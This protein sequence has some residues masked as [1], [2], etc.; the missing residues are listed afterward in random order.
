MR[1]W[2]DNPLQTDN[3]SHEIR[4]VVALDAPLP[5]YKQ[6]HIFRLGF[7]FLDGE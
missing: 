3:L 2:V 7:A 6:V 5:K 4:G 1:H